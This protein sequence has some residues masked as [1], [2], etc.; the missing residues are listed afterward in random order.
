MNILNT[1]PRS[2][3]DNRFISFASTATLARL[4]GSMA[5]S[6]T[7]SESTKAVQTLAFGPRRDAAGS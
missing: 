4:G 2:S 1:F 6:C 7:S 3:T 5:F